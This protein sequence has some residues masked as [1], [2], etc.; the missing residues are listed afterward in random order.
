MLKKGCCFYVM[1]K[2]V[3]FLR[4]HPDVRARAAVPRS[5]SDDGSPGGT[6]AA[7]GSGR[8]ERATRAPPSSTAVT[9]GVSG[10]DGPE[11]ACSN[12]GGLGGA[13]ADRG[14]RLVWWRLR[15]RARQ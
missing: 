14:Q 6:S 1:Q 15:T 2:V 10:N 9:R 7:R 12:D 4:S 5:T 11:G 3:I 13:S 8:H